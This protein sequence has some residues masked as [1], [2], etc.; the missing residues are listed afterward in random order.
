MGCGRWE[1]IAGSPSETAS[2]IVKLLAPHT[3]DAGFPEPH[4]IARFIVRPYSIMCSCNGETVQRSFVKMDA[5]NPKSL[6]AGMIIRPGTGW[7]FSRRPAPCACPGKLVGLGR[8][9]SA[10]S[11]WAGCWAPWWRH[12][13][14][15]NRGK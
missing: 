13:P 8:S 3:I 15:A 9:G 4:I 2:M 6:D 12:K 1:M 5:F 14:V 10:L 7:I 11:D